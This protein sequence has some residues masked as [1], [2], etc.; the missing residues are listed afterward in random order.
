MGPVGSH[1]DPSGV[2]LVGSVGPTVTANTVMTSGCDRHRLHT[3]LV[4]Y[5]ILLQSLLYVLHLKHS[6][7][8]GGLQRLEDP[9]AN[10]NTFGAAAEKGELESVLVTQVAINKWIV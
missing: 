10:D 3:H 9:L 7:D 5:P 1:W 8:V 2:G 4:V 6:E